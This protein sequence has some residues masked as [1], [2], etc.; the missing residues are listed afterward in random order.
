MKTFVTFNPNP[1]LDQSLLNIEA[2]GFAPASGAGKAAIDFKQDLLAL[3]ASLAAE[4]RAL[5]P[6]ARMVQSVC[7]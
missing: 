4:G 2:Y 3:D 5:V 6:V 7:F 1:D